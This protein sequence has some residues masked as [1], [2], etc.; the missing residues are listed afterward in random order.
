M[1][2]GAAAASATSVSSGERGLFV[3]AG[4]IA[5]W[6]VIHFFF[7]RLIGGNQAKGGG[8]G[9]AEKDI[10]GV[11]VLI[12]AIFVGIWMPDADPW[13]G[14]A[15]PSTKPRGCPLVG[16]VACQ[17]IRRTV[18]QAG[19]HERRG[20]LQLHGVDDSA[21]R[22]I[23]QVRRDRKANR[24]YGQPGAVKSR[25]ATRFSGHACTRL[26]A[27]DPMM[28]SLVSVQGHATAG[29]TPAPAGRGGEL[30]RPVPPTQRKIGRAAIRT[31][32]QVAL[33]AGQ[34]ATD[35]PS[36]RRNGRTPAAR[37]DGRATGVHP[38]PVREGHR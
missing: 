4:L 18:V 14:A 30:R 23:Q 34:T 7:H 20:G 8:P 36:C 28:H 37:F 33:P 6:W 19:T 21:G 12:A 24:A 13:A 11:I 16:P 29:R 38:L 15:S 27:P 17:A 5:T 2:M 31:V 26:V 9:G 1:G 3:V 10:V 35:P 25:R 22:L 32:Q